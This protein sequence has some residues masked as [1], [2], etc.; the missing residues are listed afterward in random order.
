MVAAK[1]GSEGI[2]W[3]PAS[4]AGLDKRE[5]AIHYSKTIAGV[6]DAFSFLVPSKSYGT[7]A[8]TFNLLDLGEQELTDDNNN[9]IGLALPRDI[10]FAGSYAT[11][12]AK[13]LDAGINYKIIEKRVDCSGICTTVGDAV[14]STR[15]V[16]IGAQYHVVMGAPLTFGVAMRN[17]GGRLNSGETNR[18]DP[19]PTQ[20]EIGALYRL[21]FLDRYVKDTELRASASYVDGRSFGGKSMRLGTEVIYEDKVHLRAG[22]VGHDRLV[23][24]T[25]SLG[26]GLQSGSFVFDI[27]RTFGGV[28]ADNGQ[29]PVWVSL[30]YLF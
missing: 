28:Q 17:L 9:P 13:H 5:L 2:W 25:A 1:P 26:F 7:F 16:D 30:R 11:E 27:A 19:L 6:G 18:R 29:A 21:K 14:E 22:Y 10:V 23:D 12:I 20:L 24:A 4:L 15:A 8:L 3:N